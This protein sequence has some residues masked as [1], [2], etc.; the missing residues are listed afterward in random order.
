MMDEIRT[1]FDSFLA[2]EK[3]VTAERIEQLNE[4]NRNLK[5]TLYAIIILVTVDYDI[6]SLY[7]V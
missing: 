6:Y 4:S 1:Q 3:K 7:P 2:N 5:I